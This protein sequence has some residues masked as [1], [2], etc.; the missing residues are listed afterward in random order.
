MYLVSNS[1]GDC[2]LNVGNVL[3]LVTGVTVPVQL[4]HG[5]EPHPCEK[6]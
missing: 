3:G 4:L 2:L 6:E 1:L 5:A